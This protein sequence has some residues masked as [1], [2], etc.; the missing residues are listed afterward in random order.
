L[1][2]RGRHGVRESRVHAPHSAVERRAARARR[3]YK[4]DANYKQNVQDNPPVLYPAPFSEW[5]R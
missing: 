1:S 2:E 3:G 4:V 5:T